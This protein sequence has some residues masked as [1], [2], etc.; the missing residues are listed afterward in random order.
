MK[1]RG[2]WSMLAGGT[3]LCLA[4]AIPGEAAAQAGDASCRAEVAR[5]CAQVSPGQGR[6]AQCLKESYWQLSE[7]CQAH[8]KTV[9]AGLKDTLQACQDEMLL[10]CS[11]ADIAGGRSAQCLAKERARLS[12]DCA[13]LVN[14]LQ[15]K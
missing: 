12:P 8:A 1:A 2:I 6:V 13:T 15:P 10:Y 11:R 14:L 5:F 4:L 3:M 7:G 9:D